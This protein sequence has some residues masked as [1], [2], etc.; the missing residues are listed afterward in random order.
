LDGPKEVNDT[1]RKFPNGRRTFDI[2]NHNINLLYDNC[3]PS[4]LIK[5]NITIVSDLNL[6]D[7][8]IY[9]DRLFK[10]KGYSLN[11]FYVNKK[12]SSLHEIIKENAG[13][14]TSP[15]IKELRT[16]FKQNL[17]NNNVEES[18]FVKSLFSARFR[19]IYNRGS[20][21]QFDLFYSP[22]GACIPGWEKLFVDV[23]GNFYIYEKMTDFISIGN[24]AAGLNMTSILEIINKYCEM[25]ITDC[26]DCWA[27]RL[28]K[29]CYVAAKKNRWLDLEE[30]RKYCNNMRENL[31]SDIIFYLE[32][33]EKNPTAFDFFA[34]ENS[35]RYLKDRIDYMRK[36]STVD[37]E[38]KC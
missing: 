16:M 26:K 19:K 12:E 4:E 22:N 29:A 14:L 3:Y 20:F 27:I 11:P 18:Q 9:F 21:K 5:L 8:I 17:I 35:V 28:C 24:V 13:S 31:M 38:K 37:K 1:F 25:C 23:A 15:Y 30:R 10:E 36:K 34:R 6:N 33:L 2:I 32:V 7:Q